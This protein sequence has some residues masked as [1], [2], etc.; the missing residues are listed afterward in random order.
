MYS[1]RTSDFASRHPHRF[2]NMGIAEQNM[3]SVAAGLATF[4]FIPYAASFASFVSLL[5]AEQLRTDLAYPGLPV[6][7]LAHHAGI[8]LGFY[9]TRTTPPR[10]SGCCARSRR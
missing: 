1:N 2:L 9:G 6:R 3:L 10:T 5:G 7:V 4:G 8:S